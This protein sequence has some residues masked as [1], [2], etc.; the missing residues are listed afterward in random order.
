MSIPKITPQPR[1]ILR[2]PVTRGHWDNTTNQKAFLAD[3]GKIL[4]ITDP[5]GWLN[6]TKNVFKQH[7]GAGLLKKFQNSTCKLLTNIHPPYKELCRNFVN[8]IV[9]DLKLS[10]VADVI[11]V[12][13]EYPP[14]DSISNTNA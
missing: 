5:E 8:S 10:N 13:F 12:P 14:Q 9:N 1:R 11:H 6:V 4:N 2:P 7:G 3:L